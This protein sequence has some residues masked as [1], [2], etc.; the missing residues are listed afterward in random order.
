MSSA[1][2]HGPQVSRREALAFEAGVKLGG[3]FHQ[4]L[5][6]PVTDRTAPLLARSIATAVELQPY[7][8]RASVRILPSRGGP[9]G[10]GRY[11]YRYLRPE[12]LD[13]RVDLADGPVRLVARLRHRPR[14]RY[15]L[16]VIER[17]SGERP[18]PRASRSARTRGPSR[19]RRPPSAGSGGGRGTLRGRARST[20]RPGSPRRSA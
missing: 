7:V 4:Y 19:R 20:P 15:P 13:V 12:M 3:I 10:R 16:M 14:L 8:R 1:A 17:L 18:P 5:G 6:T 2:I 11:A 9:M